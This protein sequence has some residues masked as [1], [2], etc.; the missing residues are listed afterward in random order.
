MSNM[1]DVSIDPVMRMK[2]E[3]II[4]QNPVQRL[5]VINEEGSAALNSNHL[6]TLDTSVKKLP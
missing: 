6:N 2:A 5:T 4:A 1:T 3:K